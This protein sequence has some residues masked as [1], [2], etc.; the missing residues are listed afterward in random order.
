VIGY[1]ASTIVHCTNGSGYLQ[2]SGVV[3]HLTQ[4]ARTKWGPKG[5]GDVLLC[6]CLLYGDRNCR[7]LKKRKSRNA[8]LNEL[9]FYRLKA[10][11]KM[12]SSN[13][14]VR[15]RYKLEKVASKVFFH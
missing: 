8:M 1:L 10:R 14:E 12:K 7:M 3:A 6:P 11:K 15:I 13:P 2:V 5:R 9:R 4:E